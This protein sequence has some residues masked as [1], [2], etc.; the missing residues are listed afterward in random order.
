[1]KNISRIFANTMN[2]NAAT[3]A[4]PPSR[5][6]DGNTE[7]TFLDKSAR[8]VQFDG[9][10]IGSWQIQNRRSRRIMTPSSLVLARA[11]HRSGGLSQM[12]ACGPPLSSANMSGALASMKAALPPK[13]WWPA[14]ALLTLL[15]ALPTTASTSAPLV[16]TW[17]ACA[18]VNVTLFIYFAA[19]TRNAL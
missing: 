17:F 11:A 14:G 3:H 10:S 13:P 2:G 12:R 18:S 15:V 8:R 7:P 4:K 6:L 16:W 5:D 1:S 9:W 19:A